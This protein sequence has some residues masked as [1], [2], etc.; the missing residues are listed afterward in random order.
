M[1]CVGSGAEFGN[2]NYIPNMGEDYFQQHI[3]TN[4]YGFSKYVMAKDIETNNADILDLRVLGFLANVKTTP[5]ALFPT[6]SLGFCP[7]W[8]SP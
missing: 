3:P 5:A 4:F 7:V 1:I 8:T 2:R 6:I